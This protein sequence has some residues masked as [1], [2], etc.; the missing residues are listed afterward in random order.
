[1]FRLPLGKFGIWEME[2]VS[3]IWSVCHIQWMFQSIMIMIYMVQ[4]MFDI[5]CA[6]LTLFSF[7]NG[8]WQGSSPSVM[9]SKC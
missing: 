7:Y 4:E 6:M 1:M 2:C 8:V 9:Q 5:L 3:S